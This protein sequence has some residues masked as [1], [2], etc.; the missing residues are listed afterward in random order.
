MSRL[1]IGPGSV[2]LNGTRVNCTEWAVN[3]E[4]TA[5]AS[6]NIIDVIDE[7]RSRKQIDY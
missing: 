5:V 4:N 6:T 2:G 7:F 1:V 3:N